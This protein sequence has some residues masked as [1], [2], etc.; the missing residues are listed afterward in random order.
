M[1]YMLL[2][3]TN[4]RSYFVKVKDAHNNDII[5]TITPYFYRK[6][7]TLALRKKRLTNSI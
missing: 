3:N 5:L 7:K 6:L 1:D 2:K 4:N